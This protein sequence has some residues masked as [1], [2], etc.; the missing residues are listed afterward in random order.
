MLSLSTLGES[1]VRQRGGKIYGL[2]PAIRSCFPEASLL[3]QITSP[4]PLRRRG[5]KHLMKSIYILLALSTF[6]C[7][8]LTEEQQRVPLEQNPT[9]PKLTKIVLLA[10]ST[11]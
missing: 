5:C 11:S 3:R 10:G 1:V 8:A 2:V 7:A 4:R 6:A 9:D